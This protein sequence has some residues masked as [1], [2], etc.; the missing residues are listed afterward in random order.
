MDLVI[1]HP[2]STSK[3][4]LR[5]HSPASLAFSQHHQVSQNN[6]HLTNLALNFQFFYQQILSLLFFSS[7]QLGTLHF[8]LH[9]DPDSSL[10]TTIAATYIQ[11]QVR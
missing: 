11:T 7:F 6:F 10:Q 8:Q 3:L 1:V 5:L 9:H 4:L 2:C